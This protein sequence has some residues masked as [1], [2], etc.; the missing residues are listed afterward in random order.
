MSYSSPE[1]DHTVVALEGPG[2]VCGGGTEGLVD[3]DLVEV[4]DRPLV[5]LKVTFRPAKQVGLQVNYNSAN[6]SDRGE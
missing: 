4:T 5:L 6:L 2:V 3:A 1:C